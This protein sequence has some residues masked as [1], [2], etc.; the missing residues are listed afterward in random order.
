MRALLTVVQAKCFDL[1]AFCQNASVNS[2]LEQAEIIRLREIHLALSTAQ[3]Q[4]RN[5]QPVDLVAATNDAVS[6][7]GAWLTDNTV[8][9]FE[10]QPEIDD[11]RLALDE[12]ASA[13]S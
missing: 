1:M 7:L 9:V 4:A 6:S 12:A 8:D 10:E 11:L 5:D 2:T 13:A 3:L